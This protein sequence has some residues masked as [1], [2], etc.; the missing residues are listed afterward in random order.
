M[1]ADEWDRVQAVNLR[2]LF[3]LSREFAKAASERGTAGV[4]VNIG[5]IDSLHPQ[6][7]GRQRTTHP[8][9]AF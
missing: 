5:P 3:L 6:A 2:G 7:W 8:R 9:V 4:I 1:T